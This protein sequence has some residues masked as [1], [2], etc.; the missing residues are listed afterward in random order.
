[1]K[2]TQLKA[3]AKQV[4]LNGITKEESKKIISLLGIADLK[5]FEK[6]LQS[7]LEKQTVYITSSDELDHAT[8][9]RLN[10]LFKNKRIVRNVDSKIGGGINARVYDMI[11]DLSVKSSIERIAKLTQEEI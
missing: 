2:N 7:E 4:V 10:D 3:F 1:M 8:S 11:Y 9:V 6:M 5:T